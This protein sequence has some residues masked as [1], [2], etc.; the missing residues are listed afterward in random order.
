MLFADLS[1][2]K[3]FNCLTSMTVSLVSG[4]RALIA[5]DDFKHI[6]H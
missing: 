3:G 2:A 1:K 5:I 6:N 4:T